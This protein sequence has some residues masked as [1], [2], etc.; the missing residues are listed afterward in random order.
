MR[1]LITGYKGQLGTDLMNEIHARYP[2]DVLIGLDKEEADLTNQGAV[3][4]F[5]KEA[6]PDAIMHLAAYTAV[7]KAEE[8]KELC[9]AVNA[10]G[11][12]NICLAAK[13]VD[14]KILYISTDYVF[15][16][17]KPA[18]YLPGDEKHP[19]S[20]YGLSK[21]IGEDYVRKLRK[22]FVVRTSWVFGKNGHN[23]IYTM[24]ALAAKG[25][26]INVVSDQI[27]SPT[28]TKHLSVLIDEMI[29]TDHYGVYHGTNENYV[30]WFEFAQMI[31]KKGGYDPALIHPI[32]SDQYKCLAVR[33]HNSR[34]DKQC[35]TAAGF[36]HLPTVEAALDEFLLETGNLKEKAQ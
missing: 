31:L 11:T 18:P 6:K 24:L 10:D 5:V 2:E 12:A 30:T 17:K 19:L 20:I 4:K 7:D 29:H 1:I 32:S 14:A 15:D 35:L 25:N 27:G 23:F 33:P 34:L 28:Y 3:L 22:S 13:A 9:Y 8:N 16:G 36:H 21:S 26:P